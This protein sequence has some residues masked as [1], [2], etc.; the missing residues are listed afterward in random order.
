MTLLITFAMD[1]DDIIPDVCFLDVTDFRIS[2]SCIKS[3][4]Q[5]QLISRGQEGGE[6]KGG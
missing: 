4:G 2:G 3:N 5:H 6:V 1:Q